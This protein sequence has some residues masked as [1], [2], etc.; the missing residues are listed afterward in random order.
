M[1]LGQF[2]HVA[3]TDGVTDRGTVEEELPRPFHDDLGADF[4]LVRA[5]EGQR[6]RVVIRDS[7]Q[8]AHG[9][10]QVI[11]DRDGILA[12]QEF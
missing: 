11:D 4:G 8:L 7:V 2:L 1:P 6:A 12:A 10:P 5:P 3:G 9:G